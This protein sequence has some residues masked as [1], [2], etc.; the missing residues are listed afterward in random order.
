MNF[1][2]GYKS[3]QGKRHDV[4]QDTIGVMADTDEGTQY[5]VPVFVVA[6]GLGGYAGGEVASD[7]A[8]NKLVDYVKQ[9]QQSPAGQLVD[10]I[11][12]AN[13]S[14]RSNQQAEARLNKMQTTV[15]A[16][17]LTPQVLYVAN[18]GDSRAYLIRDHDTIEQITDDHSLKAELERRGVQAGRLTRSQIT[19]A[20][21]YDDEIEIDVFEPAWQ[22]GDTLILCS[23]GLWSEVTESQIRETVLS[24]PPGAAAESLVES[25]K[26][27]GAPDDISI[28][29]VKYKA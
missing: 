15:V 2:F 27:R 5:E 29:I 1:D 11:R 9:H 21:G 19:R 8:V 7:I 20:I 25:V 28:I 13:R 23:D 26:R 12:D 3:V 16:A 4:N 24:Q 10:G 14:V 22:P 18:I 6:D 17:A